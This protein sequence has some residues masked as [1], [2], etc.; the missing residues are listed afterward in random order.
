MH[1]D[2]RRPEPPER[3]GPY[4]LDQLLGSG[5]MGAVWRAWDERL[6]RWV[7][8]KQI[9]ADVTVRHGRERL[10]REARAVARLSHPAIVHVYDILEG[11]DG[12]WIV[13]EL[14][15]GGTLRSLL[16]EEGALPPARAVRLCRE[17]AEGLAEAH[18]QGILHR[19]LKTS[20]VIV[21]PS[22]RAKILDFGLA[23][24]IPREGDPEI[25]ELT[26]STPGV[27][28]GTAFAMSPEQVLGSPLDERSDLFSLG[29]LFY[30]MLTGEAPFKAESATL[31][32]TR[33]LHHRVPPLHQ[34]H[35]ELPPD[36]CDLVDWL[37]QKE[38]LH[39]PQSAVQVI[40]ALG[41]AAG[42]SSPGPAPA[43]RRAPRADLVDSTAVTLIEPMARS[44]MD[45]E[46]RQSSGERRTVTLVCCALVQT[47]RAPGDSGALDVEVLSEALASFE[48]LAREV[49]RELDGSLGAVLNRMLWLCFGYPRAHEDYAE[50]ALRAAR[51]LQERFA[52]LPAAAAHR[53]A[54]RAGVH[55]G[56]A[57][58]VTRPLTGQ[59]LQ[60]GDTFDVAMAIQSQLPAGQIAVSA[61]SRQLLGRRFATR[62]LPPVYVKDL[63]TTV[64][65]YELG[66]SLE[67][68]SREG[69]ALSPLVNR[70][71]EMQILLDRFRLARAGEGQAVLIAGE[72]GIGKSRLVRALGERLAA[73]TPVWLSTHG[74]VFAQNTP[75]SPIVYLLSRAIFLL[76]G[77][78]GS[79]GEE[80][81]HRL[82]E[83]LD[84]Y[85]L[86]RPDHV[87]FL[88]A[89]LSVPTE[90]RY[91]PLVLSPEAWRKR[92]LAAILAL[93]GAMA[94]RQPVVL[95]IEDLHWIDPSTLELLDLL[96]AEISVLSLLLVATFRP[97][98]SA[99]WRHQTAVTQLNL[100]GL[101][102]AHTA[103]LIERVSEG[104]RLPAEVQREIVARTDGIP[105][106]VEE[107]T[108]TV[109]EG[110]VTLR[111]PSGIPLTLGG[112]LLA[113]LDRL[114]EAK[115]VAQLAAVIG[116]SFTLEQLEALSWIKGAAL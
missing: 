107:L 83:I 3:L 4:R 67:P 92:T 59:S 13:M 91:P 112:S 110:D 18:A 102:E 14:V 63:D 39:R 24:E 52:A 33:V 21:G 64:E 47:D 27:I 29:S 62:P 45:E 86:P 116:R 81:L 69:G 8:L 115:A 36:V 113:R 114:G 19:D 11:A 50:R 49:C 98:F 84:G 6:E 31:S 56:P 12:D 1:S 32:I 85:G 97:E 26:A 41:S 95:V 75:L 109:L 80:R 57:V 73:E 106:F 54:V 78:A 68:G 9:R 34:S 43:R 44:V 48:G 96:M 10:R 51:L 79:S 55:T 2:N 58:V 42:V 7:A 15:E 82:E 111:K 94:E 104:K 16:D 61:A 53:L 30:E 74:S 77:G 20:N 100:G 89:L 38:P 108:K 72:A 66:P 60:P 46:S 90:A 37:L 93:L 87:P 25:Q 35:P 76:D 5:G 103:E 99:P 65:V 101:S 71:A 105:L 40:A 88:G 28:L 17:I 23:K 70:E 22:G